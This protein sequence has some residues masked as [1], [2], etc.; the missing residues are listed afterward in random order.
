LEEDFIKFLS[1]KAICGSQ[2]KIKNTRK[3]ME[4]MYRLTRYD[5]YFKKQEKIVF[6]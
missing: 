2:R 3:S 1:E 4:K 5:A 6:G